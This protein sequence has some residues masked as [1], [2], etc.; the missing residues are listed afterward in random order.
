MVV[1]LQSKM[2]TRPQ[3]LSEEILLRSGQEQSLDEKSMAAY[4]IIKSQ[5]DKSTSV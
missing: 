1:M 2:L 3:C 5:I 4:T